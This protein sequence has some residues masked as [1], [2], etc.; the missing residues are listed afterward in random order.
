MMDSNNEKYKL[1]LLIPSVPL[2]ASTTGLAES[3]IMGGHEQA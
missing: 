2:V 1:F 3:R